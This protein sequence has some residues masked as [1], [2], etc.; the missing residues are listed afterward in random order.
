LE[1]RRHLLYGKGGHTMHS[2]LEKSLAFTRAG[3]SQEKGALGREK[4]ALTK[5]KVGA[6]L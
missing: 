3:K 4:R 5:T 6:L 2:I 1:K